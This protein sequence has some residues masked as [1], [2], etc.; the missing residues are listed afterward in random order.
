MSDEERKSAG[1]ELT[2]LLDLFN[3]RQMNRIVNGPFNDQ[4]LPIFDKEFSDESTRIINRIKELKK[5][6]YGEG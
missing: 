2:D 6:V 5:I 1:E 4:G 3:K